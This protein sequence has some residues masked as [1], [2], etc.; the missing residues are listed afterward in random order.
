MQENKNYGIETLISSIDHDQREY[1]D[2]IQK[3]LNTFDRG[4]KH[5]DTSCADRMRQYPNSGVLCEHNCEYCE[6]F[7][8]TIDRAKHYAQKTGLSV[9][10]VL[11][12]WEKDRSY[13]YL[14]YY[15]DCNQPKIE[16]DARIFNSVEDWK[17]SVGD[18]GFRCTMCG[19]VSTD[20]CSCNSGLTVSKNKICDWKTYGLI[21]TGV[22]VY[23][24]KERK[25]A[26]IFMPIA[27]EEK[28]G[29]DLQ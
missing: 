16:D 14:N 5:Y 24:I 17:K 19:G 29:K 25:N 11:E 10:E 12:S 3:G 6:S 8:W 4:C 22:P 7:R 9:S 23:F 18:K 21:P 2:R 27:W 28:D 26:R 20:P 13:W 1:L 15:Q